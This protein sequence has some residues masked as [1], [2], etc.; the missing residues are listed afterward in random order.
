MSI[1]T[2]LAGIFF[3]KT[4]GELITRF[5]EIILLFL[6]YMLSKWLYKRYKENIAQRRILFKGALL[7]FLITF[8]L[9]NLTLYTYVKIPF[10]PI[11]SLAILIGIIIASISVSVSLIKDI[12]NR[13][14]RKESQG[15]F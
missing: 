15:M 6:I 10:F 9:F 3:P 11:F 1:F 12:I 7:F 14:K 8:F 13:T 5:V 4:R 2:Y